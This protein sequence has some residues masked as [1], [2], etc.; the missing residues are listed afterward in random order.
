[1]TITAV[2]HR[3]TSVQLR[4]LETELRRELAALG[5]RLASERQ[6]ES[7][8]TD[9]EAMHSVVATTHRASDIAERRDIVAAALARLTSGEYGTCSRCGEAIPY[10]RLLVMPEATHCLSCSGR[11]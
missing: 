5:R 6:A 8:E 11:P 3:L 10:G 1:M 9:D 7:A 2:P 4:D